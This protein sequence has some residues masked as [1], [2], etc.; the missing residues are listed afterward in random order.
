MSSANMVK[1]QRIRKVATRLGVLARRF[2]SAGQRR[3][4]LGDLARD[5]G[6]PF[7][8]IERVRIG[9]DGAQQVRMCSAR[10]ARKMRLRW[11]SGR[12]GRRRCRRTRRRR[13]SSSRCRRR[14]GTAAA[15]RGVRR[16]RGPGRAARSSSGSRPASRA[17]WG[18]SRRPAWLPAGSCRACRGRP[19]RSSAARLGARHVLL[20]DVEVLRRVA[21]LRVRPLDAEDVAELVEE[22]VLVGALCV[23][24]RG[25][26]VN[27]K[28]RRA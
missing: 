18:R 24:A 20:E 22:R 11:P 3:D 28:K 5:G 15:H 26:A 12:R 9:P 14:A 17:A 19:G 2:E 25:P 27:G 13:R 10:S 6:R 21:G 7:R 4:V 8:G 1:R 23:A 16:S